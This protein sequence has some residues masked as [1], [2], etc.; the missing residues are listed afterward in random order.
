MNYEYRVAKK[1]YEFE[2]I[3]SLSIHFDNG[4]FVEVDK[5]EIKGL[6]ISLY[7]RLV[8]IGYSLCSFAAEGH[9]D[10]K[11]DKRRKT[12]EYDFVY[13]PSEIKQNRVEYIIQRLTREQG[14]QGIRFY[15]ENNWHT[16]VYGNISADINEEGI[17]SIRFAKKP[18]DEPYSS[19]QHMIRLNDITK[20]M[21][22]SIDLD[23]ENCENIKV[24]KNEIVDMKLNFEDV[25]E[26]SGHDYCRRVK[27]GYIIL[28]LDGNDICR[29]AHLNRSLRSKL[30]DK[31]VEERLCGK[32]GKCLHDICNLYIHYY[33]PALGLRQCE[34]LEIPDIKPEE[35]V[36][37]LIESEE[38]G[39]DEY[40][41]FEGGECIKMS[42]GRIKITFGKEL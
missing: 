38:T 20:D 26:L 6:S 29:E 31:Q 16:T 14:I 34:H 12:T 30:T 37:R 13:N 5:K 32:K 11:P 3:E 42:D 21:V 17:V 25:L 1:K 18:G 39:G 8:T 22:R 36:D 9:I 24:Y 2:E 35:E 33:Y 41:C 10:I 23:F 27:N 15:S 7:D 4:D 40:Y 28:K 19:D